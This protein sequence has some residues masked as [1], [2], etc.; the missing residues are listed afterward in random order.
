VEPEEQ[1]NS[2]EPE[3]DYAHVDAHRPSP[4]LDLVK[5][6]RVQR[7]DPALR[8]KSSSM[9]TFEFEALDSFKCDVM[10]RYC[11]QISRLALI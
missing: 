1:C 8:I 3:R 9:I 4:L 7:R 11:G 6:R 10:R 5:A 2:H